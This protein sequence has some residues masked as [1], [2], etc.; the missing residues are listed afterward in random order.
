MF[1]T[2][3]NQSTYLK[4]NDRLLVSYN[5]CRLRYHACHHISITLLLPGLVH[6]WIEIKENKINA[7]R[8]IH[9]ISQLFYF[10]SD[11]QTAYG[12]FFRTLKEIEV[13]KCKIH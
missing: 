2:S 13:L 7:A 11:V 8:N 3:T 6:I 5:E 10:M 12:S 9:F 4:Q 1:Y